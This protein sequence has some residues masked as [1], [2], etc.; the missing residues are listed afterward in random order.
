[1]SYMAVHLDNT[2]EAN[3]PKSNFPMLLAELGRSKS[4]D[5]YVAIT[6]E[7]DWSLS[8]YPSGLTIWQS[9]L[10]ANEVLYQPSLSK[11]KVLSLWLL[12][13]K[14]SIQETQ[15]QPWQEGDPG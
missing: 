13:A 3:Y 14:G 6:H 11:E 8:V 15:N 12:L 4:E 10:T 1:M 5:E 9:N 2:N 7:S